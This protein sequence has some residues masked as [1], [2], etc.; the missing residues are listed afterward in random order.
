MRKDALRLA[1][2]IGVEHAGAPGSG[3]VAPP[4]VDGGG[5]L[6]LGPPAVDRQAE[7]R[8]RDEDVA[9]LR[10]ERRRD[11]VVLELVVAGGDPDLA[12]MGHADLR[13]AEH[14]SRRMERNLDAVTGQRLAVSDR[15]DRDVAEP[16]AQERRTVAM[17]NVEVRA[18]TGMVAVRMGD[19]RPADR[20][21][22]IDVKV[23]RGAIE[24][25]IGRDDEV[26]MGPGRAREA[27]GPV[28]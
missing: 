16:P 10:L 1:E 19:Q 12:A 2:R 22:R 23:A 5:G 15:L 21:P 27:A 11:A 24:A 14:V 13:R 25:A 4:A 3:V 20:A 9:A 26:H 8:F 7:G 28:I 6:R 18:G 17:A